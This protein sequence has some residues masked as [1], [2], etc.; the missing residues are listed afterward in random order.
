MRRSILHAK[1]GS[2][3]GSPS[4]IYPSAHP[5]PAGKSRYSRRRSH[6]VQ[7]AVRPPPSVPAD[8]SAA[9]GSDMASYFLLI[10][11]LP[12]RLPLLHSWKFLHTVPFPVLRYQKALPSFPLM[13]SPDPDGD[14]KIRL[15]SPIPSASGSDLG[16]P[17]GIF[18]NPSFHMVLA[19][20]HIRLL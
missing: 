14:G 3:P 16:W 15:H 13:E 10:S 7:T 8:C 6:Q 17:S 4:D 19:R 9:D 2:P 20:N 11:G 12:V 5:A 1:R 18:W